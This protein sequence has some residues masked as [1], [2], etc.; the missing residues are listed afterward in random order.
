[1]NRYK[2][3]EHVLSDQNSSP[4]LPVMSSILTGVG[5]AGIAYSFTSKPLWIIVAGAAGVAAPMATSVS[6]SIEY[7]IIGVGAVG[8][9]VK[10]GNF[11]IS[12]N[13]KLIA[14][15]AGGAGGYY[16]GDQSSS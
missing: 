15:A 9:A 4:V 12:Q 16:I 6:K 11:S 13:M 7:A 5:A 2:K 1:L 14:M 3:G 10:M 8:A